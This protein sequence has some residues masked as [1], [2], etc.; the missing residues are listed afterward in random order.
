MQR[1]ENV[2]EKRDSKYEELGESCSLDSTDPHEA[3]QVS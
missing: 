1:E 2:L 3:E